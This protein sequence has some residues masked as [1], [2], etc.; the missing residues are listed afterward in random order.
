MARQSAVIERY[1]NKEQHFKQEGQ[2]PRKPNRMI[3]GASTLRGVLYP[4]HSHTYL[5]TGETHHKDDNVPVMYATDDRDVAIYNALLGDL[6]Q[7]F[8]IQGV[9]VYKTEDEN[10]PESCSIILDRYAPPLSK[11]RLLKCQA[12]LYL[13]PIDSPGT[14]HW[15]GE[16]E[17]VSDRLWYSEKSKTRFLKTEIISAQDFL[18]HRL[19]TI[20]HP[21]FSTVTHDPRKRGVEK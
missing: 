1:F 10:V 21:R 5:Y 12:I 17:G 20:T 14:W 15:A 19:L 18:R 16:V 8:P 2:S 9:Q 4:R 7:S 3:V 6:A 13:L 11:S